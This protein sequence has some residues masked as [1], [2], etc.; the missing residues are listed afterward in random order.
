MVDLSIVFCKRWPEGIT[1]I[2]LWFS[3]DFPISFW[4]VYQPRASPIV[5]S[6]VSEACAHGAVDGDAAARAMARCWR[7][8][9]SRSFRDQKYPKNMNDMNV[10]PRKIVILVISW[11][12]HGDFHGKIGI[13][14]NLAWILCS[15]LMR[16]QGLMHFEICLC[17]MTCLDDS[18]FTE[19]R[20]PPNKMEIY[21]N[22]IQR[23]SQP[24]CP[25]IF[26]TPRPPRKL[27]S[28]DWWFGWFGGFGLAM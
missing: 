23:R 22:I 24:P 6:T 26:T 27:S 25:A 9:L 21:G 10:S 11:G 5:L 2:F 16:S 15:E 28:L 7:S 19:M 17:M 1:T 4:Y 3:Y 14:I 13:R 18:D 20:N 8:P 12:F